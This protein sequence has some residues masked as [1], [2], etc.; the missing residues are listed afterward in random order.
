M[1]EVVK[2]SKKDLAVIEETVEKFL[3][4][5][6]LEATFSLDQNEDVVEVAMETQDSGII[7]GYHGEM[8]ESLQLVLSLVVAK[9]LGRF[10]R[11]SIEVDGYK[12]NRTEYLHSLALQV[13]ERALAEQ[14]EQALMSLKSWERRAVHLFLQNDEEVT[15]ESS[16]EG[17]DR[18][19]LIRPK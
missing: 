8:L 4:E 16:G 11:I 18:V 14:K 1:E 17:R 15:S 10:V 9:K 3:A 6:E 13:K 7:I 12:K 19:L 5:L 2:L